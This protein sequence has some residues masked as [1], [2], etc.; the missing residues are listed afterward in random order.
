MRRYLL[1]LACALVLATLIGAVPATATDTIAFISTR[2][3]TWAIY[4]MDPATAAATRLTTGDNRNCDPAWS[5]DGS[6]IA[7]VS[8]RDGSAPEIYTMNADG[9]SQARLTANAAWD[10]TP[11]WS[12]DGATIAFAS[13]RDGD[14]DIYVMR[15]DGTNPLN[16][17]AN[18]DRGSEKDPAWSPDGSRIAFTSDREGNAEVYVM[19]ADG[20][21]LARLTASGAW[22]GTPAWSPDGSRIAFRSN[23]D[24][25]NEI[26]VMNA[27]GSDQRRLTTDPGNDSDPAW[28][29]D[30]ARIVFSNGNDVCL[31]NAD[32]RDVVRLSTGTS[33][34]WQDLQ[35]S[36]RGGNDE[37]SQPVEP[38]PDRTV[39]GNGWIASPYGAYAA[40]PRLTG[41]V[42]FAI[43]EGYHD[44]SSRPGGTATLRFGASGQTFHS[45]RCD[46]LVIDGKRAQCWGTGTLN[47]QSGYAFMLTTI[48]GKTTRYGTVDLLRIKVWK[49]STGALVYDNQR[50]TPESAAPTRSIGGGGIAVQIG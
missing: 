19:N 26:Y 3:G 18:G 33:T 9:G 34:G 14:G 48:D 47:G 10:G 7:F 28:S 32:G 12:P 49:Q 6:T 21:G 2:D 15:A 37:A 40:N 43:D 41:R 13:D 44:G 16:L 24:G 23:R 36:W 20:S 31:M 39:T 8:Y 29:P 22:D 50:G 5:P 45:T 46:R 4:T 17:I 42:A 1:Y 38:E 27:D 35:P 11:A 30:G 25:N